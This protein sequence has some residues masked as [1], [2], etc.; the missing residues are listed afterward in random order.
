MEQT[1][2]KLEPRG[3]TNGLCG[4]AVGERGVKI[5]HLF[6]SLLTSFVRGTHTTGFARSAPMRE[7]DSLSTF[8]CCR[9]RQGPRLVSPVR[10]HTPLGDEGL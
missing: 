3:W 2:T 7:T 9:L 6:L 10:P 1:N 5:D 4:R 8:I